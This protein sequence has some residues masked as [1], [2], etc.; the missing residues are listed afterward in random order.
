MTTLLVVTCDEHVNCSLGLCVQ[1]VQA[2][3][4][5]TFYPSKTQRVI[6]AAWGQFWDTVEATAEAE[7]ADAIWWLN[8][9]DALDL[10]KHDK[11]APITQNRAR[12]MDL[13]LATYKRPAALAARRFIVRGT[14]AHNGEHCDLEELLGRDLEAEVCPDDG[15]P[16]WWKI[17]LECE[18]VRFEA[19]HH[20]KT[21]GSTPWTRNGAAS[22]LAT[23]VAFE[24]LERGERPPDVCLRGHIHRATDSG[25]VLKP[26]VFTVPGWQALNPY[27]YRRGFFLPGAIGGMWFVCR[28]GQYREALWQRQPKRQA[29]WKAS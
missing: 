6:A 1:P 5:G 20:P 4:G 11:L 7:H 18:G 10:N 13:G 17:E 26:R 29:I 21:T 19:M 2:D 24:Y 3:A 15:A 12:I 27:A 22:R 28:D 23:E 14:E 25:M 16:A 8:N 9:G